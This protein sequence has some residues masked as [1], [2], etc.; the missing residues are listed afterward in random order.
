MFGFLGVLPR[1]RSVGSIVSPLKRMVKELE[2]F[3]RQQN[4]LAD[5]L[6]NRGHAMLRKSH[7][8]REEAAKAT[9][10]HSRIAALIE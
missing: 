4:F 7:E 2:A 9:G 3:T 8:V 6:W 5:G 1:R 10:V